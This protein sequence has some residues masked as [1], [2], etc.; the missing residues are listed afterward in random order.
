MGTIT[1]APEPVAGMRLNL[2]FATTVT[3][4]RVYRYDPSGY[5]QYIR[6]GDTVALTNGA[7]SIVDYEAPLDTQVYW[8]AIQ[9][10]PAGSEAA[11]S[12]HTQIE[13]GGYCYLKD[14]GYPSRNFKIPVT[15]SI[16]AL[17][18]GARA[19][20]FN[21]IDRLTPIVVTAKRGPATGPIVL[22]TYTDQD[23][24]MMYDLL[25]PGKVLLFQSPAA[26][27]WGSQY[28]YIADVEEARV[29]LA[30]EQA[31]KWT[32][33][34]LVVDRPVGLSTQKIGRTWA[35]VKTTWLT[36]ADVKAT[37]KTWNQVLE[38]Q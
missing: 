24:Q 22:H 28:I 25:A 30:M 38:G 37:N 21:I 16:A 32:L 34:A 11:T 5:V 2:S 33:P 20:V 29:G 6:S 10:T 8:E 12:E 7:A 17:S 31:R 27:G 13:S 19:G 1:L 36:W 4:V 9:V 3:A 15:T 35:D 14:P 26:F 23:R 18:F